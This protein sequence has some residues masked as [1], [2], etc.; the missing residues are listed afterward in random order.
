MRLLPWLGATLPDMQILDKDINVHVRKV[1]QPGLRSLQATCNF[2]AT[3]VLQALR[4]LRLLRL[5]RVA[6]HMFVASMSTN[7]IAIPGTTKTIPNALAYLL[8]IFYGL[9]VLINF[10]GC[11]WYIPS[12]TPPPPSFLVSFHV[13]QR[14]CHPRDHQDHPQRPGLSAPDLLW[15]C[16]PHQLPGLSLVHPLPPSFL[17]S[18]QSLLQ[19]PI[20]GLSC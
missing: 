15:P 17:V 3:S 1:A 8:Q 10:L 2:L 7:D 13:H 16:C 4:A 5:I 9:A 19:C 11:L 18:F 12:P 6:K 14:H 20:E